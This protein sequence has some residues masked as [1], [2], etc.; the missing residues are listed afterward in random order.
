MKFITNNQVEYI[1]RAPFPVE[2]FIH[3]TKEIID[4]HLKSIFHTSKNN[5]SPREYA[6]LRILRNS[7][8]ITIKPADKNLGIVILDT[9][10][11][12]Q[13]SIRQLSSTTYRR[14]AMFPESLSLQLQNLTIKFKNDISQLG[15]SLLN[16]LTPSGK[17]VSQDF[18]VSQ[19][20]INSH[21]QETTYHLFVQ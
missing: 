6:S 21:H 15:R 4:S 14:V 10:D 3:Y 19:K 20:S 7:T 13:E 8:L 18:T 2:N 5:L 17:N 1:P 9:N 12:V 16:Y 11:Y